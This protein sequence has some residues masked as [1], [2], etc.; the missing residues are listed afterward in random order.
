MDKVSQ[1][2]HVEFMLISVKQPLKH[3]SPE[4]VF[5]THRTNENPKE[6]AEDVMKI[7]SSSAS[8]WLTFNENSSQ[9]SVTRFRKDYKAVFQEAWLKLPGN[10]TMEKTDTTG[11]FDGPGWDENLICSKC[12][13][14]FA[15]PFWGAGWQDFWARPLL[16]KQAAQRKGT[17]PPEN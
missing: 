9:R 14:N 10:S 7:F 13:A 8:A 16:K 2:N 11:E 5:F 17:C 4:C 6:T 3:V 15:W 1:Q 12:H